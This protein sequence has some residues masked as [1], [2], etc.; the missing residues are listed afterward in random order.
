MMTLIMIVW[1]YKDIPRTAEHL[2]TAP[3]YSKEAT[4]YSY[5]TRL[6]CEAREFD[7]PEQA[8]WEMCEEKFAGP[9]K[10]WKPIAIENLQD[11][12]PLSQQEIENFPRVNTQREVPLSIKR[13]VWAKPEHEKCQ[14]FLSECIV[15]PT[16][17]TDVSCFRFVSQGYYYEVRQSDGGCL[18]ILYATENGRCYILYNPW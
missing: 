12:P 7:I 16:G 3:E 9:H 13:Y 18:Y 1:W 2:P 11:L 14:P 4:N 15:D 17:K 8:F 5:H 10:T 6:L